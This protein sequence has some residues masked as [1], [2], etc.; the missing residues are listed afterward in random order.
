MM[1]ESG[2]GFAARYTLLRKLATGRSADTWLARDGHSGSER[3][4]KIAHDEGGAGRGQFLAGLRLQQRFE[5]PN[6]LRVLAIESGDPAF[7]VLEHA[8][9]G[10]AARLRG[11]RW[12]ELQSLLV[13]VAEGCGALHELGYVHGDLKTSNV[14]LDATGN[15]L[16]T[17][18]ETA[19][20]IGDPA[21][22]RAGSPFAMSPQQFDGA[23]S[24]VADDVYGFGA[25]AYELLSG[26]PPFYPDP[27]P[28][29]VRS[30][31]PAPLP[32]RLDVPE[33]VERLV[34]EC[35]AKNPD[36]R[37]TS[38]RSVAARLRS[39]AA[40]APRPSAVQPDTAQVVLRAPQVQAP[41]IE[42]RWQRHASV[43]PSAAELRSQGFRRGLV[44]GTLALLLLAAAAV[45]LALPRWVERRTTEPTTAQVPAAAPPSAPAT[46]VDRDL[47]QLAGLK[48]QYEV[49]R[50]PVAARLAALDARNAGPWAGEGYARG[51]Q[52]FTDAETAFAA[53]EYAAA[54][55]LLKAADQGLDAAEKLAAATLRQALAAGRAAI[56]A[57]IAPEARRQFELAL[58]I[59][60]VNAV[61]KR[62]L[63][64]TGTLDEVRRLLAA[65]AASERDGQ[66]AAAEAGYRKAL[67]LDPDTNA[68]REALARMQSAATG[69]AFAAAISQ[70]LAATSRRDYVAA[71]EAFERAN[72]IRPG[73]AEARD[74]L[75]A[76][77]RAVGDRAIGERL[78]AAQRA[79]GEERWADAVADFR[80]ALDL[81]RNLLAAQQGLERAEP[82]AMLAAE[83]EAYMGKPER[84][85][86][87][88]VRGAA[89]AALA[90]AAAVPSPGPVLTQQV[91]TITGLLAAAE[92]PVRVEFAS[93]NQTEVTIYRVGKLGVFDRKDMELLPGRYTV[94]GTRTGF[95]DVRREF[96]ILP[97][98]ESAALVIR[99]EEQI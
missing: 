81:D 46:A 8:S 71:R 88:E 83:L 65:A 63:E 70:G 23:P 15:A 25:L 42:P 43:G 18:F 32:G 45:F 54:L 84:L 29:R 98:R 92:T 51:R 1:L 75:A 93:D 21:A 58:A 14:V 38:L 20:P 30:E 66:A 96:T 48:R 27:R 31:R 39:V 7:A 2:Q 12:P 4:L 24:S 77:E 59:D 56:D 73:S 61:A 22:S 50:P 37:P 16:L 3:A 91:A 41:A 80:K 47:E 55:E 67:E 62:G 85:F 87:S 64:R 76:V 9:G 28:E 5:H 69:A 33:A 89:R 94:V 90:R 99:C 72:R 36:D 44:V 95:R 52:A 74:G 6:V 82:R 13:Q 97:G 17:D 53:Q 11:Q 86:S 10:D 26:Y 60:P 79:E 49:A 78:S 34:Q 68:A 57:G 40:A 19:A 35:L